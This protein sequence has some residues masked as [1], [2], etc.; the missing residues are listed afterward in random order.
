MRWDG[1]KAHAARCE[2]AVHPACLNYGARTSFDICR[3]HINQVLD[4][5]MEMFRAHIG[6][7]MYALQLERW[8]T[9]FGRENIK[10]RHDLNYGCVSREGCDVG[11]VAMHCGLSTGFALHALE[12]RDIDE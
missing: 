3:C 1:P 6:K 12:P 11:D 10:V 8:F 7:G 2:R 9:L 5:K 4:N